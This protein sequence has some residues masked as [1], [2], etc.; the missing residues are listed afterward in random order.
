MDFTNG[1]KA[2]VVFGGKEK[3]CDDSYDVYY[4]LCRNGI[5]H[6]LAADAQSWTELACAGETYNEED[7]DIYME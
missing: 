4:F 7:F 2:L 6:E 3:L 5:K 1:V